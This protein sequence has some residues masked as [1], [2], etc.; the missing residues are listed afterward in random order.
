[1]EFRGLLGGFKQGQGYV[2]SVLA[3][4][5]AEPNKQWQEGPP[6]NKKRDEH[7]AVVCNGGVYVMGGYDERSFD[8]IER[9]DADDLLHSSLTPSTTHASNW[10]RLSCRL[11]T[12]R[13]GCCAVAVQN[14]YI[15]V[16]GGYSGY[17]Y[18]YLSA[19][20]IIDTNNH[21]VTPGPSMTV[22]RQ[23]CA[24]AV[25]DHRIFVVGG[26]NDDDYLDSVEYFILLHLAISS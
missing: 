23:F 8:S 1:M 2:N 4:N 14:R 18:R 24:S 12:G 26:R 7:A 9:I 20:D 25:V 6:M 17:S 5:L 22:N 13:M 3:L 19:V 21:I 15:V 10:T 11:S 16:M